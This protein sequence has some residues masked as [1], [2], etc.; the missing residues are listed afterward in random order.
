M[1]LF[2]SARVDTASCSA[3]A[4][5]ASESDHLTP[6][7]TAALIELVMSSSDL[8]DVDEYERMDSLKPA[9]SVSD[10]SNSVEI[11]RNAPSKSPAVLIEN[12]TIATP[13]ARIP[14]SSLTAAVVK[15]ATGCVMVWAELANE[16]RL[17]SAA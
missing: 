15:S 9:I 13:A 17:F 14:A 5:S 7:P 1:V 11:C 8:L 6:E 4:I 10:A 3:V 2:K 12:A 16:P